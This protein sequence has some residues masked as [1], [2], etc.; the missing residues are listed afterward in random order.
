MVSLLIIGKNF[1]GLCAQIMCHVNSS[2]R[3]CKWS[4]E[5]VLIMQTVRCY[6]V[7]FPKFQILQ[8]NKQTNGHTQGIHWVLLF[9]SVITS[10]RNPWS[11]VL[12]LPGTFL[13]PRIHLIKLWS[14]ANPPPGHTPNPLHTCSPHF[15]FIW[16]C[17]C[18]SSPHIQ[19]S[20]L[21]L[22]LVTPLYIAPSSPIKLYIKLKLQTLWLLLLLLKVALIK[23]LILPVR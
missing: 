17:H 22:H 23:I 4:S 10:S 18:I 2:S 3:L 6:V 11:L 14:C 7:T 15:S 20:S 8:T 12:Y 1:E 16:L 9:S 13:C 19:V 5:V 21:L